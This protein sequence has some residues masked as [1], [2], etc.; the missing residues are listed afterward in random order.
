LASMIG[1]VPVGGNIVLF[2][3]AYRTPPRCT[4]GNRF[5]QR[6]LER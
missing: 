2:H 6:Q 1:T 5:V 4:L 3:L